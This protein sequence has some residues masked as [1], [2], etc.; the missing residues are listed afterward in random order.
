MRNCRHGPKPDRS[1]P[2]G[3]RVAHFPTRRCDYWGLVKWSRR[4]LGFSKACGSG[5]RVEAPRD[6]RARVRRAR[7]WS[8]CERCCSHSSVSP[9]TPPQDR[10]GEAFAAWRR[11]LE[12]LPRSAQPC[13]SSRISTGRTIGLLDFVDLLVDWATDVPLLVVATARP[14]PSHAV[15]TG[16]RQDQ[17]RTLALA[18][19]SEADT[20]ELVARRDR[21]DLRPPDVQAPCWPVQAEPLFMSRSSHGRSQNVVMSTATIS[22]RPDWVQVSSLHGSTY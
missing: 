13:S 16:A 22:A 2:G 18:P 6:G 8:G 10:R 1:R 5:R 4:R 20:T 11:F 21:S 14:E 7:G 9:T 19:L 17:C 12:G 15:G 3:A